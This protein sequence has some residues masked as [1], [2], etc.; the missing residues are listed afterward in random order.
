MNQMHPHMSQPDK[1]VTANGHV[2]TR[3]KSKQQVKKQ[4]QQKLS[5]QSPKSKFQEL[6]KLQSQNTKS[7]QALDLLKNVN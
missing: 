3:P 4:K 2:I 7:N 1:I 6:R 5:T